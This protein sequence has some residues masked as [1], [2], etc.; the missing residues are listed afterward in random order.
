MHVRAS[1]IVMAAGL[2]LATASVASAQ[3]VA[4]VGSAVQ[5]D[6]MRARFQIMAMEGVLERAVQLGAQRMSQQ[7]Q[8]VSS[9]VL[10]IATGARAKGFWL[11]GYGV[12]FDVDVPAMRHSMAWSVR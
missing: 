11:D 3:G 4:S 6:Q 12:F 8:A 7:V 2:G 5:T 10:F 9:D 1:T